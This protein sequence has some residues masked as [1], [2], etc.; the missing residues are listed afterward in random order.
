LAVR[1]YRSK[2]GVLFLSCVMSVAV[3]CSFAVGCYLIACGLPGNHLSLADHFVVMPLSAATQVIPLPLGPFEAVLDCLYS[4]VPV[5]GEPIMK[6][7]GLLVALVYRL[8]T[9]LIAALGAFYYLGNRG[10]VA[11]VM[12]EAERE[13]AGKLA[14]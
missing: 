3:H 1:M 5:A 8:I 2:P 7:Q 9:L 4:H 14:T 13:E 10:E 12:H 11:Q 6:G